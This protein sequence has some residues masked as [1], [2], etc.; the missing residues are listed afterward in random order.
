MN[1]VYYSFQVASSMI[2]V[3]YAESDMPGTDISKSVV[4]KFDLNFDTIFGQDDYFIAV[5]HNRLSHDYTDVLFDG[6]ILA[7]GRY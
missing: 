2:T 5:V 6:Y 4:I 3:T 7:R 1:A